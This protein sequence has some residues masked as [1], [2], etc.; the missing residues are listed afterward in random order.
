LPVL[1]GKVQIDAGYRVDMIIEHCVIVE[2]KVVEQLLPI[3]EAQLMTYRRLSS[4]A[5]GFLLNWNVRL[6]KNG[7]KRVVSDIPDPQWYGQHKT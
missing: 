4:I 5:I 3:H 1:Y 2:N 6:I 7:I